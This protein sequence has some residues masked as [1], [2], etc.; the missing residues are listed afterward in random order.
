[1]QKRTLR[2]S[3]H[4]FKSFSI[5][6]TFHDSSPQLKGSKLLA[7]DIKIAILSITIYKAC[8]LQTIF[9]GSLLFFPFDGP[10]E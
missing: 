4:M 2:Q 7:A 9:T 8:N 1:M 10:D 6:M 3:N 5:F